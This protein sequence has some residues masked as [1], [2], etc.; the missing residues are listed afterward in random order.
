MW[1]HLSSHSH[2]L[3]VRLPF[4]FPP[5]HAC[6]LL[7]EDCAARCLR[8]R[9]GNGVSH[10]GGQPHRRPRRNPRSPQGLFPVEA[11]TL[12]CTPRV[13]SCCFALALALV[14]AIVLVRACTCTCSC[15]RTCSCTCT[16]S[17][18]CTCSSSCCSPPPPPP[19][20][21]VPPFISSPATP[22]LFTAY[23]SMLLVVR[24]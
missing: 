3:T 17:C 15:S 11:A 20:P 9:C 21:P 18:Y 1:L 6:V 24:L 2:G 5:P 19:P 7:C 16:C 10:V 22:P 4:P 8:L 12:T 23:S 13:P 14:L